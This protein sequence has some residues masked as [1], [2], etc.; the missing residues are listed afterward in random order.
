MDDGTAPAVTGTKNVTF[1]SP[2]APEPPASIIEETTPDPIV[3]PEP[4]P[5]PPPP[6]EE[7]APEE[8]EDAPAEAEVLGEE[9]A[10]DDATAVPPSAAGAASGQQ[11]AGTTTLRGGS[12]GQ[13]TLQSLSFE[14]GED[15]EFREVRERSAANQTTVDYASA[16]TASMALGTRLTE[17]GVQTIRA[18]DFLE[19]SLDGLKQE[20]ENEIALNQVVASSAIAVTTG[21]SMG[22]VAWLLRSGVLLSSLLSSMPAW[23]FLDPLPVLAGKLDLDEEADEESL[24]TIIEQPGQ[25]T[26]DGTPDSV[27][28]SADEKES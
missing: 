19:N 24:E 6:V 1:T 22:Y 12:S 8:S 3:P 11:S 18:L 25:P 20:A 5:E 27:P 15:S 7:P 21:L 9:D 14:Q 28:D 23:R 26:D 2:P 4:E 16:R 10:G 13:R 17:L